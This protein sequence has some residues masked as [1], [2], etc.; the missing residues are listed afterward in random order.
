MYV[1]WNIEARSPNNCCGGKRISIAYSEYVN[2]ALVTQPAKRMR[3][4]TL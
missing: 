4:I 3:R 1:K 2:V